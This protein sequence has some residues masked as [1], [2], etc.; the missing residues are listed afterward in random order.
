MDAGLGSE[1]ANRRPF[2]K[3]QLRSPGVVLYLSHTT[4]PDDDTPRGSDFLW[5]AAFLY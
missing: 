1:A 3:K 4:R 2:P 5:Q